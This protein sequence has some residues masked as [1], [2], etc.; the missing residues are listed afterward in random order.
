MDYTNTIS[1]ATQETNPT[2]Y[3]M[4]RILKAMDGICNHVGAWLYQMSDYDDY[5]LPSNNYYAYGDIY[6]TFI[7]MG[8]K[9]IFHQGAQ[10]R[11]TRNTAFAQLK[12]YLNSKLQWD[13]S[14]DEQEL[15]DKFFD[16]YFG[17]A[18]QTMQDFFY[19]VYNVVDSNGGTTTLSR[20]VFSQSDLEY[21]I[22]LCEQALED[23][24]PLKTT[25]STRYNLLVQNI[26][27]EMMMPRYLLIRLYRVYKGST[28]TNSQ[29]S[30]IKTQFIAECKAAGVLEGNN[31]DVIA[32]VNLNYVS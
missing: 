31:Q 12:L 15:I 19:D 18:S 11:T 3:K 28:F 22:S 29:L 8:A 30:T 5:F 7:D 14:L 13:A 32:N 25:D 16:G 21:W 2:N 1:D 9:W 10:K 24:A 20:N 23:I 27:C 4:L 6:R 17:P 26:N